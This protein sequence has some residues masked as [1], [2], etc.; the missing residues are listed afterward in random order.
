MQ[1][2]HCDHRILHAPNECVF[3]DKHPDWQEERVKNNINFTNE[4]DP[5]K[6]PCPAEAARGD[7]VNYWGGNRPT[8]QEDLDKF[9]REME[10][11]RKEFDF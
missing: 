3:C 9:D 1:Y 10:E 2:P 7:A 5:N 4:K 8:T 6:L 11:L